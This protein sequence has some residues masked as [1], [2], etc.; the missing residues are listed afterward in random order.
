MRASTGDWTM[1]GPRLSKRPRAIA[2]D[3]WPVVMSGRARIRK[4]ARTTRGFAEERLAVAWIGVQGSAR[5][6]AT[7]IL[8]C[9]PGRP[10]GLS[11]TRVDLLREFLELF[12]RKRDRSDIADAR[13]D[14][15]EALSPRR[16]E[17]AGL[18]VTVEGWRGRK[19]NGLG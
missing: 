3:G 10:G 14:L 4:S 5:R 2:V 18:V 19:V 15:L 11:R 7:T 1:P 6:S 17:S 16:S 8:K 12:C 13:V 9:Q